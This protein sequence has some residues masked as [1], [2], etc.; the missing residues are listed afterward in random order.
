MDRQKLSHLWKKRTLGHP[1]EQLDCK[2]LSDSGSLES[3]LSALM[4]KG[5]PS[6]SGRLV[7]DMHSLSSGGKQLYLA[8]FQACA[9]MHVELFHPPLFH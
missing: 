6:E 3:V 7:P 8:H 5:E 4:V 9:P 1:F 2:T